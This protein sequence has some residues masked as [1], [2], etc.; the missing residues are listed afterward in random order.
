M[1]AAAACPA[2]V[3][4]RPPFAG[5]AQCLSFAQVSGHLPLSSQ[6]LWVRVTEL[7]RAGV[8]PYCGKV[9]EALQSAGFDGRVEQIST[10]R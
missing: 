7:P 1:G 10:S 2:A 6:E 5:H 9:H 3:G 4:L 8:P